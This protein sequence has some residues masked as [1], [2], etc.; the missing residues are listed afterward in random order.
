[1]CRTYGIL[2]LDDFLHYEAKFVITRRFAKAVILK[3][4]LHRLWKARACEFDLRGWILTAGVGFLLLENL[5]LGKVELFTAE[6]SHNSKLFASLGLGSSLKTTR[7]DCP[8]R[9][10][11]RARKKIAY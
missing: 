6:S 7:Y 9:L 1:V 3:Q 8:L 10:V 5:C 2:T 4:S 11:V